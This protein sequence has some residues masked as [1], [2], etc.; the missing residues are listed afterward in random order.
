MPGTV[1]G[2]GNGVVKETDRDPA[3]TKIDQPVLC[4]LVMQ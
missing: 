3:G 2:L 1:V 4:G